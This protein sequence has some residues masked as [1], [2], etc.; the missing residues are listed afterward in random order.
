L[1]WQLAILREAM[2]LQNDEEKACRIVVKKEN[3]NK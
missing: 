3:A 1:L 2:W